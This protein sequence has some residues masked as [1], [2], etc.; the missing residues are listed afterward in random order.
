MKRMLT[1]QERIQLDRRVAELEKRTNAQVVIAVVQRSDTYA[2]LPWKA[3]ALAAAIAG[4]GAVLLDLLRPGWHPGIAVLFAVVS[5]LAAGAA[6]AL[7]CVAVPG[8]ARFFLDAHRAQMEVRQYAQ[9]LFLS[10]EVFAARGRRGVLLLVSMFERQVVLLPDSG[11]DKGLSRDA[12]QGVVARM[13]PVLATGQ[14]CRA[15]ESGLQ[16]LEENL[17]AAATGA[18]PENELPN[19]IEEKGT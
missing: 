7:L 6:C 1:D 2:E 16:G 12:M 11:L 8:F 13:A 19:L 10:R 17:A 14:V 9:S 4:S 5:T 18:S 15:L 3:F